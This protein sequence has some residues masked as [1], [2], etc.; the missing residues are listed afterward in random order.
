MG[1]QHVPAPG[2]KKEAGSF[3]V[4][5]RQRKSSICAF[6]HHVKIMSENISWNTSVTFCNH[7][8]LQY[9]N[10]HHIVA[11]AAAEK[12]TPL[13][14]TGRSSQQPRGFQLL[15]SCHRG[16]WDHGY[17]GGNH[18]LKRHVFNQIMAEIMVNLTNPAFVERQ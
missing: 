10:F 7:F 16:T 8:F 15:P 6:H 12:R 14:C 18:I 4:A 13:K 5:I 17:P 3:M 2:D 9:T 1:L 11:I